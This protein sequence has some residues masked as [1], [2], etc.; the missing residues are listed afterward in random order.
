MIFGLAPKSSSQLGGVDASA[1]AYIVT[2]NN[3]FYV[4]SYDGIDPTTGKERRRWQ[5]A[6][7]SRADAEAIAESL[8]EAPGLPIALGRDAATLA[9]YY[10]TAWLPKRARSVRATTAYRY[11]WIIDH[12][13]NP[14]LGDYALRSLR[15]QH[16]DD[17]YTSLLERG[18]RNGDGLAPKTVHEVHVIIRSA[19]NDA[20]DC[21]L[22]RTNAA[23]NARS[24]RPHARQR[25]GTSVW[26]PAQVAEF[27]ESTKHHRLHLTLHLAAFTGMRRGEVAGL[28]WA[29][30]NDTT[31]RLSINR[32]RQVVAGRSTEFA[33]KTRT[34]RRCTDLDPD[35]EQHLRTW[36]TRQQDD[37][38]PAGPDD[39]IFTNTAG[40]PLHAESISQLFTRIVA[41]SPLSRIRLHDLR[42]THASLLVANGVPIKVVSERLG[43]AHPGFTMATYQ[44][45]LPGMSAKAATDFANL[46]HPVDDQPDD[47]DAKHQLTDSEEQCIDPKRLP[48]R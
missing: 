47:S 24:P 34:S 15:T 40:E 41:R 22:L 18:G 4:V 33:P 44:H 21:G 46:I 23:A 14:T 17:L 6:G 2:R 13:I 5:L 3:R 7:T 31:H 16:L 45:V 38:H 25:P 10:R 35:T 30:W 9:D 42:H 12:Y 39:A 8:T 26:N 19:L 29:D 27:L 32:T 37:G 20:V 36:R 11:V 43:H 1:M 28:R 48:D